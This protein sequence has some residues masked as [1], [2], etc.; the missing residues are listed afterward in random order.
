MVH[1]YVG[2][3]THDQVTAHLDISPGSRVLSDKIRE[4]IYGLLFCQLGPMYITLWKEGY[5]EA[6]YIVGM[7]HRLGRIRF[8]EDKMVTVSELRFPRNDKEALASETAAM[9]NLQ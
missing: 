9:H 7:A 2:G 8:A 6:H 1:F 4:D 5:A 3:C